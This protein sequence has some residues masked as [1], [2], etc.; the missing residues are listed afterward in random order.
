[1]QTTA[2]FDDS[3]HVTDVVAVVSN[4]LGGASSLPFLHRLYRVDFVSRC[5][6]RQRDPTMTE[7]ASQFAKQAGT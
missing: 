5:C 7:W 4:D 1:M 3:H 2:V 6:R